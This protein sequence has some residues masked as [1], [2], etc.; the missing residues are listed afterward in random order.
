[1]SQARAEPDAPARPPVAFGRRPRHRPPPHPPDAARDIPHRGH[2]PRR[3]RVRHQPADRGH[4]P[5]SRRRLP[6]GWH[7]AGSSQRHRAE[8]TL[9]AFQSDDEVDVR[10]YVGRSPSSGWTSVWWAS[11][12]GGDERVRARSGGSSGP[13]VSSTRCTPG[14]SCARSHGRA[15]RGRPARAGRAG[16]RWRCRRAPRRPSRSPPRRHVPSSG[17]GGCRR[18]RRAGGHQPDARGHEGHEASQ[19]H[20]WSPSSAG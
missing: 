4:A 14:R 8:G 5:E 2:P 10:D 6:A 19:G 11:W 20:R 13:R 12:A 9:L 1:M 16:R 3:C 7:P 17:L 18:S 15:A